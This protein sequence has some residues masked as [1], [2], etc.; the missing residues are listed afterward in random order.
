MHSI[1]PVHLSV[2]DPGPGEGA[3]TIGVIKIFEKLHE[4]ETYLG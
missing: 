3:M 1:H 4:I 2:A